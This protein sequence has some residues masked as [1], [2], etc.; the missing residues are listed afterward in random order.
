M[1]G[2]DRQTGGAAEVGE[3]H[4]PISAQH[5]HDSTVEIFQHVSERTQVGARR[6]SCFWSVAWSRWDSRYGRD[7]VWVGRGRTALLS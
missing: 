5:L 7:Q 3:A 4:A 2:G 6:G 1:D